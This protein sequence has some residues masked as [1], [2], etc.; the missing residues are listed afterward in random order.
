MSRVFSSVSSDGLSPSSARLLLV[1]LHRCRIAHPFFDRVRGAHAGTRPQERREARKA[2]PGLVPQEDDVR[3]DRQAFF[4]HAARVVDVTV[5]RA[6]GQVDHLDAIEPPI[7]LQIE[8]R[9][10]DG[11]QRHR[12]VHRIFRQRECLDIERL[13]AGQH[14]A[15]MVRLVAVAVDDRDIAGRQ[16]RLDRHLVGGRSAVGHEEDPVGAERT[17]SLVLRA[18]D[19]AGRL[20]EAVEAAGGGAA[21]GEEQVDPVELAHVADP[22]GLE[23]RLAAG[24]RQRVEGADRPLRILLEVVEERRLVTILDAFEDGEVQLEQLL[25]RIEDAARHIRHRIAGH[26]FDPPVRHDVDVELRPHAL[27]QVARA[28]APTDRNWPCTAAPWMR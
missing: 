21:F 8:Q 2:E 15:V 5:E 11:A 19:V 25:H 17:R 13:G 1:S 16:Q 7:G 3:L 6:V 20:Q 9:L 24:D 22:V 10:L 4:H 28:A 18:L 26:G 12:A 14:H 27:D 23:H